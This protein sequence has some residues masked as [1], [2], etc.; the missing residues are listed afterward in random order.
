MRVR[1]PL[2]LIGDDGEKI[3]RLGIVRC[4]LQDGLEPLCRDLHP[5]RIQSGQRVACR[6]GDGASFFFVHGPTTHVDSI[7]AAP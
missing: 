4:L 7:V 5:T 1:K 3:V 6:C 2:R